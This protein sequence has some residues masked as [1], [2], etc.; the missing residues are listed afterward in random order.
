MGFSRQEHWSGLPCPPPGDL[1]NPG[2]E[3]PSSTLQAGSLSLR[4]QGSP[5]FYVWAF[6]KKNT[7]KASP[8]SHS[9]S[10]PGWSAETRELV[11]GGGTAWL[12]DTGWWCCAVCALVPLP[13]PSGERIRE[14]IFS[15][16]DFFPSNKCSFLLVI[17]PAKELCQAISFLY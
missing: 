5:R 7:W 11:S 3:P 8:T 9:C 17:H 15:C 6:K 10:R 4:H 12:V 2:I 1:P 14:K 13:S 16:H